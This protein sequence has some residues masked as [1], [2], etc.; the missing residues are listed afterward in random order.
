MVVYSALSSR[1][2]WY[3]GAAASNISSSN[4]NS[5][6][7]LLMPSGIFRSTTGGWLDLVFTYLKVLLGFM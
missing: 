2:F 5:D 7:R 3:W 6:R 4:E 1:A